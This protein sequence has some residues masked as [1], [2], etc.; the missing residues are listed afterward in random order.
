MNLLRYVVR[1]VE[2][3]LGVI[4]Q[5]RRQDVI[6]NLYSIQIQF[7][8]TKPCYV[9]HRPLYS[10]LRRELTPQH[11]RGQRPLIVEAR[12]APRQ[13]SIRTEILGVLPVL[14][15]IDEHGRPGHEFDAQRDDQTA[16]IL[17]TR[18]GRIHRQHIFTWA[19]LCRDVENVRHP[20]RSAHRRLHPIDG[21]LVS[22]VG[23][24]DANGVLD[25]SIRWNLKSLAQR[26][27]I[28]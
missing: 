19:N 25:L 1:D 13:H 28:A 23:P 5:S 12:L 10:L 9:S 4:R 8:Q 20:R 2:H 22:I 15:R 11:A 21:Q 26:A 3:P 14:V 18:V 24:D 17:G 6:A 27:F 16:L 7:K